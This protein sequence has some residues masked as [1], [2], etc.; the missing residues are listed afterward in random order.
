VQNVVA[1]FIE[2]IARGKG[3]T[4]MSRD[5]FLE[6]VDQYAPPEFRERFG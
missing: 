5:L 6:I 1:E 3:A 4:R 2:E